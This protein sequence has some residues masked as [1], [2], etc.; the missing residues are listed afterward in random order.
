MPRPRPL[1]PDEARRSLVGRFAGTP[2]KPGLADRL[3]Q[4][5]TKFGARSTRCFL[6]WTT[7]DGAERGEGHEVELA[8]RELLPTPVVASLDGVAL[9]PFTAGRLPIGTLRVDEVSAALTRDQLTGRQVPGSEEPLAQP[10]DFFYELVS[11]GRGEDPPPRMR[12]RLA[13]E[14]MRD[15]TNVCWRL[16][17]ERASEDRDRAGNSQ[18]GGDG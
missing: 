2:A 3:R 15:E 5:H 11:D 13:G 9:N 1:T 14:P 10:V 17:L 7:T 18:Q 12:F 6:V 8:R 4:L 16:L